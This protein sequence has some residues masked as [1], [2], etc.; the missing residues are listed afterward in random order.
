ME[1]NDE[2]GI[3]ESVDLSIVIPAYRQGGRIQEDIENVR[4]VLKAI[5]ASYEI[6]VVVDGC[7]DD[8]LHH[9]LECAEARVRIF[10]YKRNQGKGYAVRF[11]FRQ[12]SG[13][14]IGFIDAGGDIDPVGLVAAVQTLHETGSDVVVG[15]KRH[16]K[17]RVTYPMLR[18]VYSRVYQQFVKALFGFDLSDTQTGLKVF[19][20]SAITNAL[21]Y[22]SID[23][24]AF[25]VELLAIIRRVGFRKFAESPVDVNLIFP[26]SIG[27]IRPILG[28][29]IDTIS[30]AIRVYRTPV[31]AAGAPGLPHD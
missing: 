26:S 14:I 8:T 17:S 3:R 29:F 15:S 9:A 19:R 25:D 21:P 6:I 18:R 1:R 7:P 10:G 28:M 2:S 11:G 22:M 24:F 31:G 20:R 12:A 27:G 30:T 23:R 13:K 16:P 5:T 4:D